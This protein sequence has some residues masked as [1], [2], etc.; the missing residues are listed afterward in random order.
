MVHSITF[1]TNK[2]HKNVTHRGYKSTYKSN[3]LRQ[4]E[5][6]QDFLGWVWVPTQPT[7]TRWAAAALPPA[8]LPILAAACS[9]G[10]GAKHDNVWGPGLRWL[11][12]IKKVQRSTKRQC[13]WWWRFLRRDVNEGNGYEG[14][15]QAMAMRAIVT[16]TATVTTWV[17]GTTMRLVGYKE[18]KG[19]GGKSNGDGNE[20]GGWQRGGGQQGNG[21][22][23]NSGGQVDCNGNKKGD[24]V[25]E[26]G[27]GQEMAVA[28]K[29]A[30]ATATA[31][32]D[33]EEGNCDGGKSIGNGNA[34]GCRA[35]ATR[36]MAL[37]VVSKRWWQGQQWWQQGQCGQWQRWWGWRAKKRERMRVVRA[38]SRAIRM[39]GIKVG[40][41]G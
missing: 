30:M 12:I 5:N 37:R 8:S 2:P 26:K 25:G 41:G 14:G 18:W 35:P 13:C 28:T 27:G 15:E 31:V 34:G 29:R 23:D 39:V 21:N 20:G 24:D 6:F 16:V 38:N 40:K 7:S 9:F 11:P 22:G 17:N 10:W 19:K 4:E 1:S 36:T 3:I 33:S 32:V